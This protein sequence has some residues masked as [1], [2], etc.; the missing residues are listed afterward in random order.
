MDGGSS[1][2]GGVSSDGA[3]SCG[4]A[5]SLVSTQN[6]TCLPCIVGSCCGSDQACSGLPACLTL[7]QCMQA[8]QSTDQS[9]ISSCANSSPT[10][11]SAYNDFSQCLGVQCPGCPGLP[12]QGIADL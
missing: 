8:C 1:S 10:G 6:T 11:Q 7:V 12:E 5:G 4:A 2:D 3:T 9:C